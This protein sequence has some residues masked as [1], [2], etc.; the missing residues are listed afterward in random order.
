[1][2]ELGRQ[3]ETAMRRGGSS[4]EVYEAVNSAM[5]VRRILCHKPVPHAILST[6][7]MLPYLH[8]PKFL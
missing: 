7:L 1:M 8:R 4:T 5:E 6:R 3:W 2:E